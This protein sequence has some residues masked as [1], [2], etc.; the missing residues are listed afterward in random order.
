MSKAKKEAGAIKDYTGL[1]DEECPPRIVEARKELTRL[2]EKYGPRAGHYFGLIQNLESWQMALSMRENVEEVKPAIKRLEEITRV[3]AEGWPTQKGYDKHSSKLWDEAVSIADRFGAIPEEL[4]R[5]F[6]GLEDAQKPVSTY[7][8][9]KALNRETTLNPK[10]RAEQL[11]MFI[12]LEAEYKEALAQGDPITEK[13]F[14]PWVDLEPSEHALIDTFYVLLWKN[15]ETQKKELESYYM[16]NVEPEKGKPYLPA[17]SF[18]EYEL[19]TTF[20]GGG[21][22]GGKNVRAVVEIMEGLANKRFGMRENKPVQD[23]QKR[24]WKAIVRHKPLFC[25]IEVE[26]GEEDMA[27]GE[28][29][30][31]KLRG[32]ELHP[33]FVESL[34]EQYIEVPT[35]IRERTRIATGGKPS[36]TFYELRNYL[37]NEVSSKRPTATSQIN[38]E[39]ALGQFCSYIEKP[40]RKREYLLKAL[41]QCQKL[42][43]LKSYEETIG[44]AG[45]KKLLLH[46]NKE[47][48][49]EPLKLNP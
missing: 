36:K 30:T 48:A 28:Q 47:W 22:I 26:H 5:L 23:G 17:F 35:D 14:L 25:F 44:A 27:T 46:L 34:R 18:S 24:R 1:P 45:Q 43:I 40:Y 4:R 8:M 3:L 39:T 33:F 2:K 7:R 21:D 29:R 16:G 19:A 49:R 41:E 9:S 20:Y 12:E 6:Y 42:G 32:V 13:T 31:A 38:M 10:A 15:S 11:D 37:L